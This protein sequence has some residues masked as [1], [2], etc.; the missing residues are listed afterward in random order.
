M[1]LQWRP[2]SRNMRKS[3]FKK[4]PGN[5][6]GIHKQDPQNPQNC[7]SSISLSYLLKFA[8]EKRNNPQQRPMGAIPTNASPTNRG[9]HWVS[10]TTHSWTASETCTGASVSETSN[11]NSHGDGQTENLISGTRSSE[12]SLLIMAWA[13]LDITMEESL[14]FTISIT[15]KGKP[16]SHQQT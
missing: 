15:E 11:G 13:T 4:L 14:V 8:I 16:G 9:D 7:K 5:R 10:L 6:L 12:F 1:S 2:G 3:S